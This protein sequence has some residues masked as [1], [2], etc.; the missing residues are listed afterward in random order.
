M[1]RSG[2]LFVVSAP[3]GAGKSTLCENLRKTPDFFYSVSC[4][5]RPPRHGEQNGVDYWF[6][7]EEDFR[8]K[9]DDGS[10]LEHATVHG[11]RYGTPIQPVEDALAAGRDILLDIDVQGAAQI[12]AN[13]SAVIR[14]ALVDVFLMPPV[15][16]ELERRLRKRAT[17]DEATIQRRLQAAKG[18]MTRWREYD[19]VIL[20]GS[21]EEDLQKFRSVIMAERYRAHRL[22]LD[23]SLP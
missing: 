19:Y 14:D 8:K 18:E 2:I 10:F 1:H 21:V 7:S 9:A 16:S 23:E 13:T 11:H 6:V 22:V 5:T 3:S 20:S 12:R 17:D 15:F 4:T